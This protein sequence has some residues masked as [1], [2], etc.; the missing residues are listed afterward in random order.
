MLVQELAAP[1]FFDTEI[2]FLADDAVPDTA[3]ALLNHIADTYGASFLRDALA[4]A[5]YVERDKPASGQGFDETNIDQELKVTDVDIDGEKQDVMVQLHLI[6]ILQRSQIYFQQLAENVQQEVLDGL[7]EGVA[8][9]L[10]YLYGP[11]TAQ[12]SSLCQL[13]IP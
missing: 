7:G 13:I 10:L 11:A 12:L 8:A 3:V 6:W 5:Q 1:E 2:A 4:F 9:R